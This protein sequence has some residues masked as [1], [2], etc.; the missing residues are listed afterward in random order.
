MFYQ[1]DSTEYMCCSV[2]SSC[3]AVST[4]PYDVQDLPDK[5]LESCL[6]YYDVHSIIVMAVHRTGGY[7]EVIKALILS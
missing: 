3:Y 4:L 1:F 7:R 2:S 6:A 5:N